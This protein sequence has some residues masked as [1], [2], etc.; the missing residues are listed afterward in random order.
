VIQHAVILAMMWLTRT[1]LLI[2]HRPCQISTSATLLLQCCV[3]PAREHLTLL[4]VI[5]AMMWLTRT[6]LLI[7]HIT[8]LISTSA[9]QLI[10]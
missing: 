4:A 6:L 1:L 10:L 9:T 3:E 8:H 2:G 5:L 7:G